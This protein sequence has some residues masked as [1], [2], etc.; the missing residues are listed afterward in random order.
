MNPIKVFINLSE[1]SSCEDFSQS[2]WTTE[3]IKN[4]SGDK[5]SVGVCSAEDDP[6]FPIRVGKLGEVA[7][8]K[9]FGLKVDFGYK[10]RGDSFDFKLGHFTV[11]IKTSIKNYGKGFI[12]CKSSTG[13]NIPINKDIYVFSYLEQ[14]DRVNKF[15]NICL[16]GYCIKKDIKYF[17]VRQG[18]KGSNHRNYEISFDKLV[19]IQN[20]KNWYDSFIIRR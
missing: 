1:Y 5:Y 20:L 11:D 18:Y 9:Y 7:F 15:A 17:P 16:V 3:K 19:D 6:Y 2:C 12:Y 10:Y 8:S 14:E 4:N 13:C